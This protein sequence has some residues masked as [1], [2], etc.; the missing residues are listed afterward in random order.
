MTFD[1]EAWEDA[2]RNFPDRG[3]VADLLH[4]AGVRLPRG[5]LKREVTLLVGHFAIASALDSLL[6]ADIDDPGLWSLAAR[7]ASLMSLDAVARSC[8]ALSRRGLP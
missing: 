2:H 5:E 7:A 1:W 3:K 6:G 8:E 4:E